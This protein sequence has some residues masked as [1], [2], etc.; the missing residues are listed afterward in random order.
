MYTLKV[1]NQKGDVLDL[2][3]DP[4]YD[5]LKIDGLNP[6]SASINFSSMANFD[7]SLYNSAQLGNRNIVLTIKIYNP[8]ETNRINLYK[9]F[10]MKK[11]IRVYYENNTRS[12]YVDGYVETF[13]NNY[14][15]INQTVQISIICPNPFWKENDITKIEFSKTIDLFEFPFAIPAE[16]IEFSRIETLTTEYINAGDIEIGTIIE[17]H[18]TTDQILNPKFYNRTT[19]EFFGVN[20]DM[21]EGD[22]IR[23]NTQRGEKSVVLIRDGVETNIINNMMQGSTWIQLIPGINEIS[24]ECDE[25]ATNLNVTVTAVKCYEGV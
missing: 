11:K 14:F 23:I 1:E 10:Q 20:F 19:Q 22:V 4:L 21:T 16:G 25:G 12:V 6:P 7:G 15:T 3:G 17:L 13:E 24:Y 8:V 9:Y 5:V 18:A 2:T